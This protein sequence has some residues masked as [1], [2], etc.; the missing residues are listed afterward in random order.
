MRQHHEKGR[1][2]ADIAHRYIGAPTIARLTRHTVLERDGI[3]DALLMGPN[4]PHLSRSTPEAVTGP[5]PAT[6]DLFVLLSRKRITVP[7]KKR[8]RSRKGAVP[9]LGDF[10][11]GK[12]E[13]VE[14][15]ASTLVS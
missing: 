9:L 12:R 4:T 8:A 13:W 11:D 3:R 7:A 10:K 14:Q 1:H 5:L 6:F 2:Y 15:P